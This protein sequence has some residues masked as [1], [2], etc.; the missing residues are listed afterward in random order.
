MLL[1]LSVGIPSLPNQ[2]I[3]TIINLTPKNSEVKFV[4]YNVKLLLM[5]LIYWISSYVI[6]I[7]YIVK[8]PGTGKS[9]G[10]S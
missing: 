5:Y 2:T 9:S 3:I 4:M 1:L 8:I 7:V 10:C 6:T